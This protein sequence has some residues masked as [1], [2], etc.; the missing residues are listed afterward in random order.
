MHGR[1]IRYQ[2]NGCQGHI[3]NRQAAK[4][5]KIASRSG[6]P[7][8]NSLNWSPSPRSDRP[9][10]C[11]GSIWEL[12]SQIVQILRGRRFGGRQLGLLFRRFRG[13]PRDPCKTA[14]TSLSSMVKLSVYHHPAHS[15]TIYQSV[16]E[17]DY[18]RYQA[19]LLTATRDPSAGESERRDRH[20]ACSLP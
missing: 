12:V 9:S 20:I 17:A 1:I 16:E 18:V 4:R 2:P 14:G 19:R 11:S 10:G 15:C 6:F 7:L 3:I 13:K 5:E 8:P